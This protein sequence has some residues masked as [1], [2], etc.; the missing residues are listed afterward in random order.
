MRFASTMAYSWSEK[1]FGTNTETDLQLGFD[2]QPV[3]IGETLG[4]VGTSISV[5]SPWLWDIETVMDNT[6]DYL[7]PTSMSRGRLS[8]SLSPF[9]WGNVF[10]SSLKALESDTCSDISDFSFS[11]KRSS[12]DR[13]H[14]FRKSDFGRTSSDAELDEYV[15][16]WEQDF[17]IGESFDKS[18][19]AFLEWPKSDNYGAA[20]IDIEDG[21]K[22]RRKAVNDRKK[23]KVYKPK[24]VKPHSKPTIV[25]EDD[26]FQDID[27]TDDD[28]FFPRFHT[29]KNTMKKAFAPIQ[30]SE[31]IEAHSKSPKFLSPRLEMESDSDY[32]TY[33][34]AS[35]D[36]I[37][38]TNADADTENLKN[39]M[40]SVFEKAEI[41]KKKLKDFD[42]ADKSDFDNKHY[43]GQ[44][45]NSKFRDEQ[46]GTIVKNI[47]GAKFDTYKTDRKNLTH[48]NDRS[49]NFSKKHGK[50]NGNTNESK[51]RSSTNDQSKFDFDSDTSRADLG[52]DNASESFVLFVQRLVKTLGKKEGE[53]E[54]FKDLLK[55]A[56]ESL[57]QSESA[58]EVGGGFIYQC[59]RK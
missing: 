54:G 56:E 29:S 16:P 40:S 30:T 31:K 3:N 14:Q 20:A 19:Q 38:D 13:I 11:N 12:F 23:Y 36:K 43:P 50:I 28:V 10:D 52:A 49:N 51:Y 46:K 6:F 15:L 45:N 7:M 5:G 32:R 59:K 24:T 33:S 35:S 22:N 57:S 48:K 34:D 25:I 26:S 41:I 21:F 53:L 27:T 17:K 58:V 39:L 42:A 1:Q 8:R 18:L 9:A 55:R 47:D 44:F 37:G 2:T 4:V